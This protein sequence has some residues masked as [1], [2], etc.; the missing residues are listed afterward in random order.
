[1]PQLAF[2]LPQTLLMQLLLILFASALPH[3]CLKRTLFSSFGHLAFHWESNLGHSLASDFNFRDTFDP[4]DAA[5]RGDG[6]K[7][8]VGHAQDQRLHALL[9]HFLNCAAHSKCVRP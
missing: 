9:P 6:R 2:P 7:S 3:P 5:N 8:S 4:L 1:M